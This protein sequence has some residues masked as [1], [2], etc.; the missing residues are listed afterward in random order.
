MKKT[1]PTAIDSASKDSTSELLL[2]DRAA[3]DR[4]LDFYLSDT[5][6]LYLS[7]SAITTLKDSANLQAALSC[8]SDLLHCAGRSA[9]EVSNALNGVQRDHA[10]LL[11]NM[12][13]TARQYIENSLDGLTSPWE[14][15]P[16][17][18]NQQTS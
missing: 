12:V 1:S 13:E 18:T 8:A 9:N 6:Q 5:A 14:S 15:T 2:L 16:K 11:I 10:L 4:A 3:T 17:R 7:P